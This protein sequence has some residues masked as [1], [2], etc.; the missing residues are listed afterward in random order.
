MHYDIRYGPAFSTVFVTLNPG[1][2]FIAEAGAMASMDGALSMETKL[3]GGFFAAFLKQFFAKESLF[4]NH[5]RNQ[6]QQ[7]LQLVL[8]QSTVGQIVCEELKDQAL[9]FQPGAYIGHVGQLK[10]GVQWAGLTSFFAGEGL[11]RLRILGSGLVFFGAYGGITSREI[12]GELIVD[13]GHLVAYDPQIKMR[14][15]LPGGGNFISGL[16]TA[17]TSG[18]GLINRVSGKG[19]LYLQSRSIEGFARFLAPKLF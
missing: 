3:A 15:G 18:E 17:V 11:L 2:K 19:R 8:T 10:L 14:L 5:F 13:S 9:C 6:T 1:E 16:I 4:V 7:P 12:D